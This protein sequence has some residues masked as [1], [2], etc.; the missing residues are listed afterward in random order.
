[1]GLVVERNAD[2]KVL[3]NVYKRVVQSSYMSA[4]DAVAECYP[5]Q[6]V[7]DMQKLVVKVALIVSEVVSIK[8]T[9]GYYQAAINYLCKTIL[10]DNG[11]YNDLNALGINVNANK[12]KHSIDD[13]D[14][15]EKTIDR[16]VNQYNRLI[17]QLV[18]RLSIPSLGKLRITAQKGSPQ[19]VKD[20]VSSG[21]KPAKPKP[22]NNAKAAPQKQPAKDKSRGYAATSGITLNPIDPYLYRPTPTPT[23]APDN[24][25]PG[26]SKLDDVMG[27]LDLRLSIGK[28]WITKHKLIRGKEKVFHCELDVRFC[29]KGN[30]TGKKPRKIIGILSKSGRA[31]DLKEG[32]NELE[33]YAGDS[34]FP[35][36]KIT[37]T[38]TVKTGFKETKDLPCTVYAIFQ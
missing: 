1:M 38:A 30:L 22:K 8:F 31:I 26:H 23:P 2:S 24:T 10:K 9:A 19:K 3:E 27:I 37:V 4:Q 5:I 15:N 18:S 11:L 14:V 12:N 25:Q 13:L 36:V 6:F 20:K 32:R 29:G 28:G 34:Y 16:G 33:L 35:E 17:N 7:D 21:G